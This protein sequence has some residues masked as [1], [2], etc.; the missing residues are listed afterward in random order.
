M[1]P[2]ILPTVE[3]NTEWRRRRRCCC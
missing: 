1:L 3:V 2:R